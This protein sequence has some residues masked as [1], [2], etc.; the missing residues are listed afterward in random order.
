MHQSNKPSVGGVDMQ[1]FGQSLNT[2]WPGLRYLG[3]GL[4][5]AWI[6]LLSD[7]CSW[8]SDID[9]EGAVVSDGAL[10][11]KLSANMNFATA[12]TL[13]IAFFGRKHVER[14]IRSRAAT[15]I[16]GLIGI[17]GAFCII[18]SGP[19][20]PLGPFTLNVVGLFP[21]GAVICGITS[22]MLILKCSLPYSKTDP[23]R[24]LVYCLL[25]EV[26]V[27]IV[28]SVVMCES[29]YQ[30][31]AGGPPLSGIIA[32]AVLPALAS[33]LSSLG[34][35]QDDSSQEENA[36]QRP[37]RE[38]L[39]SIGLFIVMLGGL[40]TAVAISLGYCANN[41]E[42]ST[43]QTGMRVCVALRLV[44]MLI[45]LVLV[46]WKLRSV[47]LAS[48]CVIA[49]SLIAAVLALFPVLEIDSVVIFII[50][51]TISSFFD[52]T[53]WCLISFIAG[54]Q[55]LPHLSIFSLGYGAI[56]LGL[57]LGWRAAIDVMPI[58]SQSGT[59]IAIYVT[60]AI[61]VL[62]FVMLT[63]SGS[64]FNLIFPQNAGKEF[65]LKSEEGLKSVIEIVEPTRG[66]RPWKRA[67]KIVT[68]RADLSPRECD[69]FTLLSTG[70]T[71]EAIAELLS[72]SPNTVRTHIHNIYA[73]LEIHSRQELIDMVR[74]NI[75]S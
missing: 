50:V 73:K 69:V 9:A 7:T 32:L 67:C 10:L 19:Y 48:I 61:L 14:F 55:R 53:V 72:I 15:P 58:M 37:S 65:S 24:V 39:R 18:S 56:T 4:Y 62:I 45:L 35:A 26:L 8:I 42:I 52:L 54:K 16:I 66:N 43:I 34:S 57:G 23:Y 47:P 75:Q 70:Y 20:F 13:L 36:T 29:F 59:D 1:G 2:L 3:L 12:I 6:L 25:S 71:A 33:F 68:S 27:V 49:A 11:I 17:L 28:Y 64:R 74:E 22:A 38:A 51:N 31:Y 60:L 44:T 21:N 63:F 5:L 46:A 30:P 41:L 40:S